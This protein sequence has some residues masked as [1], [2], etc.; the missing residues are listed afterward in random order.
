MLWLVNGVYDVMHY[1]KVKALDTELHIVTNTLKSLELNESKVQEILQRYL[2]LRQE[3][4][5]SASVT[6]WLSLC[7]VMQVEISL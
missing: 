6:E 4:S 2:E 3:I 1:R 5:G 7:F